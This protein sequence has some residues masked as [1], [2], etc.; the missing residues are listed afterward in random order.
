MNRPQIVRLK[1]NDSR[2]VRRTVVKET[3]LQETV[4]LIKEVSCSKFHFTAVFYSVKSMKKLCPKI[5]LH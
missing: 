5:T 4:T 1:I 2:L 3:V